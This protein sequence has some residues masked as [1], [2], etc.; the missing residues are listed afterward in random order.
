M[1][2]WVRIVI[3]WF[4]RG[5]QCG[6]KQKYGLNQLLDPAVEPRDDSI[7]V[8]RRKYFELRDDS[9]LC[10]EVKLVLATG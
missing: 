1:D 2:Y 7:Y 8:E 6:K 9:C 5:I 3:P 4:S 10:G